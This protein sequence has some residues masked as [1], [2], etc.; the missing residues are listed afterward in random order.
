MKKITAKRLLAFVLA[1]V[2]V[3]GMCPQ[4][5]FAA[6]AGGAADHAAGEKLPFYQ[7]HGVDADV[8]LP[9]S[10][11]KQEKEEAPYAD[12]DSVRVSIVLNKAATLELFP[13]A[14]VASNQPAME[15]RGQ[16][17]KDQQTVAN[18][19]EAQV[20]G[21]EPLDVVWNLTL[22]AN[23]IS[24]NVL[25]GQIDEIAAVRGV[26]EVFLENQ[27]APMENDGG[28]ADPM[29]ATSTQMTGATAAWAAGYTGAGSRIAIIDTGLDGGCGGCLRLWVA[30]R[31]LLSR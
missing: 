21:G 18:R 16:L 22:A 14:D 15:Y 3:I 11:V 4:V 1:L 7:V 31:L 23:I 28:K 2:M 17:Q 26:K 9:A 12:T 20:L 30:R 8:R 13:T 19:I 24:A 6:E 25:Y 29:M 27:Y 10:Q 5:A